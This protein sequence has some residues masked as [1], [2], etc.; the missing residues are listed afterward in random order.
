[1][2]P[3]RN[4]K[5]SRTSPNKFLCARA[6]LREKS[7][8]QV[9][10]LLGPAGSGKTFLCLKEIRDALRENA[11]GPPLILLAPK[12]ATF[13]LERQLLTG[14]SLDGYTRLKFFHLSGWR[15]LSSKNQASCLPNN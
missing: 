2:R 14:H 1:M 3:E 7:S 6:S 8:V 11:G 10:F 15:D 12:Q 13:Q 5:H 9:R 4:K